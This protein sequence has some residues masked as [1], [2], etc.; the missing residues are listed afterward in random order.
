MTCAV[1]EVRKP[2]RREQRRGEC[3]G[4]HHRLQRDADR[5]DAQRFGA[6]KPHVDGES[7]AE[8]RIG[9]ARVRKR[10][11]HP[12]LGMSRRD[13]RK[14]AGDA[15]HVVAARQEVETRR[16]HFG[17]HVAGERGERRAERRCERFAGPFG[18]DD[19][20][21]TCIEQAATQREHRSRVAFGA[22]GQRDD[23]QRISPGASSPPDRPSD[24]NRPRSRG[25]VSRPLRAASILRGAQ[26]AR[27]SRRSRTR[28][29]D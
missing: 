15:R 19:D 13:I 18:E 20:V 14:G 26:R 11:A 25:R 4:R 27:S 2:V 5:H 1:H 29:A 3:T 21:V 23:A 17:R 24:R 22:E 12:V 10:R 7:R 8:D 16:F 9:A 28:C 6:R